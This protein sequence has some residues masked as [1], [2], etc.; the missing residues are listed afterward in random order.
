MEQGQ[1]MKNEKVLLVEDTPDMQIM[2]RS[3]IGD[4][5]QLTCVETIKDA[6][7]TLA[8]GGYSLV[9]LDVGLPDGDGFSFCRKLRTGES[10][11]D[12]Q[13]VFLTGSGEIEQRVLGF[14]IGADDYIT[15][16]FNSKEFQARILAKLRRKADPAM[17]TSYNQDAFRVNWPSQKA[18][19]AQDGAETELNLTPIEFKLLSHFLSNEG[20][21]FTREELLKTVWGNAVHV[22]SNTVDTHISSMRKKVG[23]YAGCFKAVVRRG[24]TY[25]SP[26]KTNPK[27]TA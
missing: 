26:L 14:D 1:I 16:P 3:A 22:S 7:F 2:V 10:F 21:I 12:V 18:Y 4:K 15:K 20:Q 6:E 25:K 24:Y 23:P 27:K 13:I 11:K 9:I 17:K 8:S 5:C 19:L